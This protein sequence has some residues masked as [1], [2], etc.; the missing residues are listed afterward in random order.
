MDAQSLLIFDLDGARFGVDA[1]RVLE[2][3][4]LPELMPVEE[5]PPWL[6]GVFALRGRIVP[7]ADLKLRFGH[8]ARAYRTGDRVVVLEADGVAMG[9]IVSD[10]LE[11]VE[12]P[13]GASQ[14]PLQ[15]DAA[16]PGGVHPGHPVQLVAG[17]A[18]I[19]DGLVTLLDVTR[20][21]GLA[22]GQSLAAAAQPAA[23][24]SHFCPAATPQ[25][26]ALFH[27]RAAALRDAAVEAE[28]EQL[29]LAVIEVGGEQFAVEMASV[30]EFCNVAQLSPIHCCPPHLL[31]AI[32]LRGN[33]VTLIDP[34]GALNLATAG[35]A[36]G[37]A[38]IGTLGEQAVGIAVDAVHD[39]VYLRADA[40]QAA[41]AALRERCGAAVSGTA[42]YAGRMMTV[43]SLPALLARQEWIVDET[44]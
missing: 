24:A 12:L 38:V 33:L 37:Q 23:P 10:V 25:D 31:G 28:G 8:A 1:T 44:V 34:R 36:G 3:I 35:A 20:L 17:E 19:G 14:Q 15:F 13:R 41:P 29:G 5:A 39:V 11:V 42:P 18:R 26:R 30:Q 22:A 9:V 27:A 21:T 7:V 16:A 2:S 40:L 43:V 6:V 32:N 4:W